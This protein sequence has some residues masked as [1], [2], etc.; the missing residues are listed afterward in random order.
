M[1]RLSNLY[2]T[3]FVTGASGGLGRA[4]AEKLL[5]EGVRVWGTA[6]DPQRL[7]GLAG[8]PGFTPVVLDLADAQGAVCAFDFA[9]QQAEGFDL[10]INN[11]G[12]GIFAP[13]AAAG[14]D[15]WQDQLGEMLATS[16]RI[17]HA[18]LRPMLARGSG[19][20]VNVASIASDFPL[21]FMSGY[22]MAKAGLSALSESLIFETRGSGVIVIDFR[23]GDYR[24]SFNSAM[25]Q[26]SHGG[27]CDP[28]LAQAWRGLE[29]N[30]DASPAPRHAADRLC[31][32]L[33]RR[34]SG[35]VRSGGLFQAH[36]APF[37]V[38]FAPDVLRRFVMTLY[39]GAR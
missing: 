27:A 2:R 32:A 7:A 13:F 37:L 11:A 31:S 19:C 5:A 36:L 26:V 6:R 34:R 3:A 16:A 21:P 14:F 28:R 1:P 4:F 33:R 8:C 30:I 20:L 38:R 9:A 23:P 10:V 12:Y 35:T 25:R 22:N 17:A 39:F 29:S 15:T 18:A 24:T